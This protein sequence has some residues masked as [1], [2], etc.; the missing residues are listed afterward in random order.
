[1]RMYTDEE[2]SDLQIEAAMF[3]ASLDSEGEVTF[4]PNSV[5]EERFPKLVERIVSKY[6]VRQLRIVKTEGG[7]IRF[8]PRH[9]RYEFLANRES[10]LA[11]ERWPASDVWSM[12]DHFG[13]SVD[14][15]IEIL[16]LQDEPYN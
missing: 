4:E 6:E 2:I 16:K 14:W 11:D 15:G 1:M 9:L 13:A 7:S 8:N 3:G 10:G 5:L 12:L